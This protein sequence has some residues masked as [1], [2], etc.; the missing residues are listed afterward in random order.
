MASIVVSGIPADLLNNFPKIGIFASATINKNILTIPLPDD[1][2]KTKELYIKYIISILRNVAPE[3]E[4]KIVDDNKS[5]KI[6]PEIRTILNSIELIEEEIGTSFFIDEYVSFNANLILFIAL[7]YYYFIKSDIVF[8]A[9]R[10]IV[11]NTLASIPNRELFL[12]E[13]SLYDLV[14]DAIKM[15]YPEENKKNIKGSP[16]GF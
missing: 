13:D 1:L 9:L 6:P 10:S 15:I 3:L 7:N 8:D 14:G 5:A 2:T 11:G 4:Y 16:D 12:L